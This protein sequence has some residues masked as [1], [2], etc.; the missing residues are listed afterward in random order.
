MARPLNRNDLKRV[1]ANL[2]NPVRKFPIASSGENFIDIK[3]NKFVL[4]DILAVDSTNT[5]GVSADLNLS[6][7]NLNTG[8]FI[9]NTIS[10]NNTI[11]S[12]GSIEVSRN[13]GGDKVT[14]SPNHVLYYQ[15]TK[16]IE[17][18]NNLVQPITDENFE[19]RVSFYNEENFKESTASFPI[20]VIKFDQTDKSKMF[21]LSG[22][23]TDT[24]VVT[25][26]TDKFQTKQ[27]GHGG[28]L[29]PLGFTISLLDKANK[30][31]L[32]NGLLVTDP[33][34]VFKDDIFLTSINEKFYPRV[35][36]S[37]PLLGPGAPAGPGEL[38]TKSNNNP[39]EFISSLDPLG[40]IAGVALPLSA[41]NLIEPLKTTPSKIFNDSTVQQF[42]ELG[43]QTLTGLDDFK[44]SLGS[45]KNRGLEDGVIVYSSY[46]S[47]GNYEFKFNLRDQ[48][49][50]FNNNNITT[51]ISFNV[52]EVEKDMVT[53]SL[54]TIFSAV[55]T[56][57]VYTNFNHLKLFSDTPDTEGATWNTNFWAYTA[58]DI[59]NFSGIHWI[60]FNNAT[61]ITPRHAICAE[62]WRAFG[63]GRKEGQTVY[64]YEHTTGNSVSAVIDKVFDLDDF[65]AYSNPT[66]IS[67][68]YT[69]HTGTNFR[70][71]SA[72]YD[73]DDLTNSI[74][75]LSGSVSEIITDC[76]L[77]HLDRDVVS[78]NDI[79][80]YPIARRIHN[81][82]APNKY[83]A[84][85]T[86]GRRRHGNG[87]NVGLGSVTRPVNQT[88]D[89]KN[90]N[91][92][93]YTGPLGPSLIMGP[94]DGEKSTLSITSG[95]L[96][97]TCLSGIV[98]DTAIL[99]AYSFDL[100]QEGDSGNPNFVIL[101]GELCL[102][103]ANF[104][105]GTLPGNNFY[106]NT[107]DNVV[108]FSGPDYTNADTH[109][110][111]Q[112]AVDLI[113]NTEGYRISAVDMV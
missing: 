49:N 86:G 1:K 19:I 5:L 113:G 104:T 28:R 59:F 89:Q 82:S 37:R 92:G 30:K 18:S 41:S 67:N 11:F 94:P 21:Q 61:L 110:L 90:N 78:G 112:S 62:H 99:T 72:F 27:R 80:V 58:R 38:K 87:D 4:P 63:S 8:D 77:I 15:G 95:A 73:I 101:N 111:L 14:D 22:E 65:K 42:E 20:S 25:I 91:N 60:G 79:K 47:A 75:D 35:S 10:E 93:Q 55:S 102:A 76:T 107:T 6:P 66:G 96:S 71:I 84:V 3:L 100:H 68:P 53:P 88:G 109:V 56:N 9:L 64:F 81:D 69:H 98:T 43:T 50:R 48:D 51:T 108:S 31:F 39:R 36:Y 23:F 34:S 103:M 32:T 57:P 45:Y 46:L 29:T 24:Q 7:R 83:P 52:V 12:P 54:S 17:V 97:A 74:E 2:S 70:S 26:S 44:Y 85:V 16:P 33:V 13:I 105:G 106:L 40:G